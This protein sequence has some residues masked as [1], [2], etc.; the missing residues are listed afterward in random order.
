MGD[1][2]QETKDVMQDHIRRAAGRGPNVA[3]EE[4]KKKALARVILKAIQAKDER[5]FSEALRRVG[6]KDGSPEWTR[7]WKIF[8]AS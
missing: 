7:A 2:S 6:V 8:R 1:I 5:A 3:K 4:R